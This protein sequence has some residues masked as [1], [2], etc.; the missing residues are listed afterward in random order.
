MV[1]RRSS[2]KDETFAATLPSTMEKPL[3]LLV[4]VPLIA[5]AAR[6]CAFSIVTEVAASDT[7]A[8]RSAELPTPASLQ[9]AYRPPVKATAI[10]DGR[11]PDGSV[12]GMYTSQLQSYID[13]AYAP[14]SSDNYS[15]LSLVNASSLRVLSLTGRYLCDAPLRLPSMFV[16]KGSGMTLTPA[17]NLSLANVSRFSA[18][19]MLHKVTLTAVIGG[20]YDAS[21]LPPPPAG[22]RGYQA[23]SIVG[24][25]GKNAV[26]AVRALANNTDASIGVNDSP[27]AEIAFSDVG[28]AVGMLRGRC[29]WTLATSSALVHDNLVRNCSSHSL[30]FDAYTTSSAAYSNVLIDHGQEGIFVEETASGNFVFNNTVHRSNGG[31]AVYSNAVGPVQRNMIIGNTITG[32]GAGLSAGGYGHDPKKTSLHNVFASNYLEGNGAPGGPQ[33]NPA[34]GA[35]SGDFWTSNT[36]AG[37][38][39]PY[40]RLPADGDGVTI[41][42]P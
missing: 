24:G 28:G 4:A 9:S 23:I 37:G 40:K 12:V 42:D 5:A 29:I 18:M 8:Y 38:G 31:I 3:L 27:H 15:R 41:F 35:V 2:V 19:V 26:R 36:I 39:F 34:H 32:N 30:D 20:T 33:V 11:L 10:V 13:E 25:P 21:S 7:C 22:S 17:H 1:A 14:V 6:G 16:L